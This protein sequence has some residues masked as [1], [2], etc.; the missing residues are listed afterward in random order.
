MDSHI[1][2]KRVSRHFLM[3]NCLLCLGA[4]FS[5]KHLLKQHCKG[6]SHLRNL[7]T[8]GTINESEAAVTINE[9]EAAQEAEHAFNCPLCPGASFDS[10]LALNRHSK[11]KRHLQISTRN[12]TQSAST[13]SLSFSCLICLGAS[14]ETKDGLK[15]HCKGKKHLE[16][17]AGKQNE[18]GIKS[19]SFN[20]TF[21]PGT[22]FESQ[23]GLTQHCKGKRH[24][25]NVETFRNRNE[26]DES[27]APEVFVQRLAAGKQNESETFRNRN[28]SDAPEVFVQRLAE[29][30]QNESDVKSPSFNC[31]F[32]PG[33]NFDSQ[34]GLTQHCKGN[35]HLENVETVRK[36]KESDA[37]EVIVQR[38]KLDECQQSIL[39]AASSS[40]QTTVRLGFADQVSA[41]VFKIMKP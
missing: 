29:G 38:Q 36:R 40:Q 25:E 14:F 35:R 23:P 1:V 34:P 32:C 11:G 7:D 16:I 33:T 8:A 24:L 19:T 28:E 18:C 27:D 15:Q 6:K 26:S 2:K 30:K 22:S 21:C 10:E 5:T 3:F 12:R 39:D 37:A 17:A 4:S 20:C 13:E 41:C 31:T 9:S